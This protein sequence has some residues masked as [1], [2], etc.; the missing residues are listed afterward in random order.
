METKK[1]KLYERLPQKM[2]T[3]Q[4]KKIY[5]GL[6]D[7]KVYE[8]IAKKVSN[9]NGDIRAAF[10]MMRNGVSS[11]AEEVRLSKD[12]TVFKVTVN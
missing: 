9:L 11:Y 12:K 8:F 1:N 4:I 2:K 6:I 5:H 10:D 7:Q 3:D